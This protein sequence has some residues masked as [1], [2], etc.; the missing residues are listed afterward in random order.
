MK[1]LLLLIL[2]VCLLMST[3]GA[4]GLAESDEEMIFLV[5]SSADSGTGTLREAL[6]TVRPGTVIQFSKDIFPKNTPTTITLFSSLP[7]LNIDNITIDGSNAGVILDGSNLFDGESGIKIHS[8]NNVILGMQIIGFPDFGILIEGG[9]KNN[10]IG[11]TGNGEG[12]VIGWNNRN[13]ISIWEEGTDDNRI[14]GNHIGIDADGKNHLSNQE[15][16]IYIADNAKGTVI[17][18]DYKKEG[19]IISGNAGSGIYIDNATETLIRGNIIGLDINK[20]EGIGNNAYGIL[21][22]NGAANVI[23]GESEEYRNVVSGNGGGI[24]IF[25]SGSRGNVVMGNEIGGPTIGFNNGGG[26]YIHDGASENVIGPGNTITF[27]AENGIQINGADANLNTV[28]ANSIYSNN[29][30]AIAITDGGNGDIPGADLTS[31]TTRS[32]SGYAAPNQMVEIYSDVENE[33]EFFE[34]S[35]QANADGFFFFL[36]T[37]GAFQGQHVRALTHDGD[38]NT[39]RLSDPLKNPGY[40][41]MKELPNMLAPS[42]VSTNA[43]VVGTNFGLALV[44][45]V[46]FGFTTSVFN[47]IVKKFQL[48]IAQTFKKI[49]PE[50]LRV[51]LDAIR[52]AELSSNVHT[53]LR[54][55][56]FWIGIVFLNAVMESFLDPNMRIFGA[57]RLRSVFSLLAAGLVISGLEWF[58]DWCAHKKLIKQSAARGELRWIGLLSVVGSV[59]FSRTVGFVPGYLLGT[60]GTIYLLPEIV[61]R[62]KAGKRSGIILAS[63]FIGGLIF[64]GSS[65]FLPIK[66]AW[67]EPLFIN[68]FAISLQGVLFE[69][70]PLDMFDGSDLWKWK[71]PVW[72]LFFLVLFFGFYHTFL[73]PTAPDVQALQQNGVQTL[74]LVMSVYGLATMVLWL[75]FNHKLDGIKKLF[76]K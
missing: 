66:L 37:S 14:I 46:F 60:M 75:I 16:G 20:R 36:L 38:G 74:L 39:S 4:R 24:D 67:L 13:G 73:N 19:N 8:S 41:V 61:D 51:L 26:V 9:A 64:W 11:G 59:L 56:A 5:T 65:Q 68:I 72:F 34:G 58:S 48:E 57:A 1:K 6:E 23:G 12:N 18:G 30:D 50:K 71:K 10:I 22:K 52:Q 17:G 15:H 69:M 42:Q 76:N 3:T 70:I 43:G 33:S 47:G 7:D 53:R 63:V 32:A 55:L 54:F 45:V 62:D 25:G 35:V 21:I 44:S 40:G 2:C 27:N 49:V 28:T 31:V 29:E